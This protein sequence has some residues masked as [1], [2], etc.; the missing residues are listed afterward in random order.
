MHGRARGE[1][2]GEMEFIVVLIVIAVVIPI[3]M[4][5]RKRHDEELQPGPDVRHSPPEGHRDNH[6]GQGFGL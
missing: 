5:W 4:L 1:E 2:V 3:V 6:T